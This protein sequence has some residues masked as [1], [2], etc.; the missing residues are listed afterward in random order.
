MTDVLAKDDSINRNQI[1][2]DIH[3]DV[4]NVNFEE[5]S[6]FLKSQYRKLRK[7]EERDSKLKEENG[8]INI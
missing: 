6:E 4:I 2:D 8:P 7:I 3:E 1:G 5:K